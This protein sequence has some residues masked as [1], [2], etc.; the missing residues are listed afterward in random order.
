M[1]DSESDDVSD[2]SDCEDEDDYFHVDS[3]HRDDTFFGDVRM[4][5]DEDSDE[6]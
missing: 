4:S 1:S 6:E 5:D 2:E 3:L